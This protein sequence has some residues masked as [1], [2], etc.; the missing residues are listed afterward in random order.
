VQGYT[1]GFAGAGGTMSTAMCG[2]SPGHAAAGTLKISIV[3]SEISGDCGVIYGT[4]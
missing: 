3:R 2:A 1:D 4:L